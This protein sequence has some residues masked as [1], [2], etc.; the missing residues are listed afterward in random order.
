M[1]GKILFFDLDGTLWDREE[2]IPPATAWALEKARRAGHMVFVNTGRTRSFALRP[3]LWDIGL[4][5]MVT[6]CGTRAEVRRPGDGSLSLKAG[7]ARVLYEKV[8]PPS[9]LEPMIDD[10]EAHGFRVLLEGAE[11]MYADMAAFRDDPYMTAV[12]KR[13]GDDLRYAPFPGSGGGPWPP[14][15]GM[16]SFPTRPGGVRDRARGARQ[17]RRHAPGMLSSR[18]PHGGYRG[19]RRWG[20]R[21]GYA[22]WRRVRRVHGRRG[23]GGPGGGGHGR[24]VLW[25][26]RRGG[27]AQAPGA[28]ITRFA[29]AAIFGICGRQEGK[30]HDKVSIRRS[31]SSPGICRWRSAGAW[32]P[33]RPRDRPF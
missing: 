10:L 4:D 23:C 18:D 29:P 27:G 17:G 14:F 32:L 3:A 19:L 22:P 31:R 16:E 26:G 21:R 11:Y 25:G 24:A 1:K 6:G 7:E 8:L 2:R 20:Q 28:C 5:G 9:V 12:E 33:R 13:S 15:G 30:T